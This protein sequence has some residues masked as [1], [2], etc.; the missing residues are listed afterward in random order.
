V[1]CCREPRNILATWQ[2]IS[3]FRHVSLSK[4]FTD[5]NEM[6]HMYSTLDTRL[7]KLYQPKDI[8]KGTLN[9]TNK[10]KTSLYVRTTTYSK[11]KLFLSQQTDIPQS[12]E[13]I[14][15]MGRISLLVCSSLRQPLPYT[16]E[17]SIYKLRQ[18]NFRNGRSV[19]LWC[20]VRQSHVPKHVCTCS[21]LHL[22]E[23]QTKWVVPSKLTDEAVCVRGIL[24]AEKW[25]TRIWSSA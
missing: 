22:H 11:I 13:N 17:V 6:Q 3:V 18:F 7:T 10:W 14:K 12:S 24:L 21:N 1:H 16:R 25:V 4:P 8:C 20:W 9:V 2:A 23:P 5:S 19:S 15:R